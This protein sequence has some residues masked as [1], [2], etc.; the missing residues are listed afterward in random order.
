MFSTINKMHSCNCQCPVPSRSENLTDPFAFAACGCPKDYRV[1]TIDNAYVSQSED[2]KAEV[3]DEA[4]TDHFPLLIRL[5][6]EEAKEKSK[7]KTIYRRDYDRMLTSDFEAALDEHDWSLLYD[8]TDANEIVSQI[9]NNV[10][11]ALDKVAPL[12]PITFRPDKPK[13]NLRRDTLEAMA[14]RD[15]A[16]KSGSR[17]NFRTLRNKVNRLVKRDKI[18][19]VLD[20]LKKKPGHKSAWQEANKIL[21]RGRG[22]QLPN[23][24]SNS[25][26]K[27]TADHQNK[28]F[29]KKV[30]DLVAT[31]PSGSQKS[32]DHESTCKGESSLGGDR[33]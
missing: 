28:F 12:K 22:S 2:A 26:P 24:T 20:R 8:T 32:P 30:A 15:S 19:G 27:D 33:C 6:V 4:L 1:A 23:C 14:S 17:T 18:R 7:L 21:G 31:L 25:D 5:K 16:R 9:V 11:D 10:V 29:I 13:L 3:L